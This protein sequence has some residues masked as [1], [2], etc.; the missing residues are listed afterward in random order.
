VPQIFRWVFI[1]LA[2]A[3]IGALLW[4]RKVTA[5]NPC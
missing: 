4:P 3:S 2:L 1:A 5:T